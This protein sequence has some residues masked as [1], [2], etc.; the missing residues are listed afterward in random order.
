MSAH[1]HLQVASSALP[2]DF[3]FEHRF[4]NLVE[5]I[6][7]AILTLVNG[8]IQLFVTRVS[9]NMNSTY[10]RLRFLFRDLAPMTAT[11]ATTRRT[12]ETASSTDIGVTV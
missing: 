1:F 5:Y 9:Q 4:Q 10:G 6:Y 2:S 7:M 11:E 12:S 3:S 8:L